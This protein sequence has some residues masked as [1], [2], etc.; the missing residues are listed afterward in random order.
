VF[1]SSGAGKTAIIK[2]I[3]QEKDGISLLLNPGKRKKKRKKKF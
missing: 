2:G 1:G 3:L